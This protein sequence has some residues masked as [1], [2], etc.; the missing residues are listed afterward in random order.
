MSSKR[1]KLQ[2]VLDLREQALGKRALELT[3]SKAQLKDALDEHS[4]ESERLLVAEKQREKLTVGPIDV[5]S[6][7]EAEQWL[8]QKKTDL[9]RAH[10][11][12]TAAEVTVQ[13][14]WDGVVEARIDKKRIELLD[15]R[16]ATT[17]TRLENRLE[18]R[19]TDEFAQRQKKH[20]EG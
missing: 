20:D 3:Q 2:K 6:W 12:V 9:G 19:L 17:E 1:R 18:Q 13:H 4:L 15:Q 7:I 10:G 5:G 16:L 14:A 8:A 11:R